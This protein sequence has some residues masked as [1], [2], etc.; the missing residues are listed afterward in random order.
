MGDKVYML[1][2]YPSLQ[3]KIVDK[4]SNF[5]MLWMKEKVLKNREEQNNTSI[6]QV[7]KEL[8][9]INFLMCIC[10]PHTKTTFGKWKCN[11]SF[12]EDI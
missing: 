2:P 6:L 12:P 4:E 8:R 3:A 1:F 11:Q 9:Y 10:I 7:D 5:G